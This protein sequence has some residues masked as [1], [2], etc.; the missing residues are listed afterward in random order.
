MQDIGVG[1]NVA[2][3]LN[4]TS[5]VVY[6]LTVGTAYWC[7]LAAAVSTGAV[8]FTILQMSAHEI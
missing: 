1:T 5:C 4:L 3:A 2:L 6:G 7:D 8:D